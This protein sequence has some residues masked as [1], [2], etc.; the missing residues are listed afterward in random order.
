MGTPSHVNADERNM[1]DIRRNGIPHLV[2]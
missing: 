1:D 2:I